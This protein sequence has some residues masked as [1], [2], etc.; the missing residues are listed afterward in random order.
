MTEMVSTSGT[1]GKLLREVFLPPDP[2]GTLHGLRNAGYTVAS[3]IAD[4][5]DNSVSA[6]ATNISVFLEEGDVRLL[7][8]RDDGTGMPEDRL[9]ESMRLSASPRGEAR[10]HDDL[11]HFG[12]G[13]KAAS[14]H[15][16]RSGKMS[17]DTL[18]GDGTGARAGWDVAEIASRGWL[19]RVLAPT[20]T[21]PGT[22]VCI[23]D[24]ALPGGPEASRVLAEIA[25][26]LAL[27][28]GPLIAR[29]LRLTVQDTP[30]QALDLCDPGLPGVRRLG[31]WSWDG[32]TVQAS[33]LI[34]PAAAG[35]ADGPDGRRAHAGLHLR[36]GGRAV[37]W[38]G[39]FSLLPARVKDT[40][41]DRIRLCISIPPAGIVDWGIDLAKSRVQIPG[42]LLPELRDRVKQGLE[43]AGRVRGIR[44]DAGHP[45]LPPE[46]IWTEAGRIDREHQTVVLALSTP[47]LENVETLLR[48]LEEL[49]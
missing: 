3:A 39:W 4:L 26:H 37:T 48:A 28:F 32:G 47:T 14:M 13:M 24:P 44:T 9:I 45:R 38:G 35:A 43:R 10:A 17:V 40:A 19:L 34:L 12:I 1:E 22:T 49:S 15:I 46:S 8:V 29:G 31:P 30:V 21:S 5:V 42:W 33:M 7:V 16:S 2:A 27:A 6:G 36:R 11:G 41:S 23:H 25:R 20:R 18:C